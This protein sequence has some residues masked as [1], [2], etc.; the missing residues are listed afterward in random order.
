MGKTFVFLQTKKIVCG[1]C[2]NNYWTYFFKNVSFSPV[3]NGN[4]AS[5]QG[6]RSVHLQRLLSRLLILE[7]FFFPGSFW[8]S[9]LDPHIEDGLC[10]ITHSLKLNLWAKHF[11]KGSKYCKS[12]FR[13]IEPVAEQGAS[14][15]TISKFFLKSSNFS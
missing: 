7:S 12:Q 9:L 6:V 5:T 1:I 13:L 14:I 15:K 10:T 11:L 2:Q 8:C 4:T 3:D